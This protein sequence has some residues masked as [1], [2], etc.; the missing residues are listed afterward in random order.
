M[1]AMKVSSSC[2]YSTVAKHTNFPASIPKSTWATSL[3]ATYCST[4]QVRNCAAA[5][6]NMKGHKLDQL[7]SIYYLI[8][9]LLWDLADDCFVEVKEALDRIA[10][11]HCVRGNVDDS[12][13]LDEYPMARTLELNGWK[14]LLTHICGFPPSKVRAINF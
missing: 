7:L 8:F 14:V 3:K 10:P 6:K 11:C 4:W 2:S 9:Q 13:P 12:A 5:L 1:E